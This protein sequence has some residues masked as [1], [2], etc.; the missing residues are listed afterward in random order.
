MQYTAWAEFAVACFLDQ[1]ES[2]ET[3][4]TYL[5]VLYINQAT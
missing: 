1:V 5:Y 4:A 2:L 3:L